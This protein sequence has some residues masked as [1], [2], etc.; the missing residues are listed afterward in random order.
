[1]RFP[2]DHSLGADP[3]TL[4]AE[5]GSYRA[6]AETDRP[7]SRARHSRLPQEDENAS[8]LANE[9]AIAFDE[10]QAYA[11]IADEIERNLQDKGLWMKAFVEARGD[12]SQQKVLYASIRL[13]EE[14]ARHEAAEE[15]RLA[16]ARA[17]QHIGPARRWR[18]LLRPTRL[19][20]GVNTHSRSSPR[21]PLTFAM[22]QRLRNSDSP[23]P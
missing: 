17:A 1:M 7:V 21:L 11:S 2:K 6:P 14:R 18:C 3:K 5:P 12:L 8:S 22:K 20:R 16:N 9:S 23:S 15:R 4:S 19:F 10:R 13:I